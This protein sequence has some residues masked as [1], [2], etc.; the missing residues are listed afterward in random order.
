MKFLV[1]GRRGQLGWELAR[2]LAPLGDVD[3]IGRVGS[4]DAPDLRG[5]P[6]AALDLE[7]PDEIRD[8]LGRLRPD[9]IVNA[10]AYTDV[11]RAEAEPELCRRV[12]ADAVAVLAAEARALGACLVH[13]SSDYVFDGSGT[14][15]W[16][17]DD[18]PAPLGVYGR[19]KWQGEQAIRSSGCRHLI[20]RSQWIYAARGAN[21]IGKILA[22]AAKRETL[23]VVDDQFG[24]PTGAELIADV[25]AH[26]LRRI[27]ERDG[28]YGT[29][30]VA[31][32]G[33][34]TWHGYARFVVDLARRAGW[35]IRVADD[36]ITGVSSE[37]WG[38]AAP[39]PRNGRLDVGRLEREFD[40]RMPDWR[41]GVARA[42]AEMDRAGIAPSAERGDGA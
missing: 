1:L 36:A 22:A 39:R 16:R 3:A 28:P 23:R 11:D 31:A 2:A 6:G 13:Y 25:T 20:L 32:R 14:A 10:A 15:P 18:D 41:A 30:H 42:V 26:C 17:E 27:I 35:P 29:F 24:A 34:T 7:R 9:L 33:E 37:D 12:N 19:A 38:A 8:V 4:A 5:E 21:F 40:L